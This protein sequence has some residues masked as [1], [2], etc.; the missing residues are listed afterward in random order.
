MLCTEDYIQ[1]LDW[2]DS[3]GGYQALKAR[4]DR[5]LDILTDW[6]AQTGW[7]EFLCADPALRSNTGVTLKIVH[8]TFARLDEKGQRAFIKNMMKRLEAEDACYDAAGYAK[9]PPGL[10]IW[11]G[12]T[13]EPD[14][15]RKLTPWLDWAFSL[16]LDTL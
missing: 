2:A 8:P 11:C 10:R 6:V 3:L 13:V 1:A 7:V 16:E 15:V 12:A 9:A 14:D 5:S 4:S